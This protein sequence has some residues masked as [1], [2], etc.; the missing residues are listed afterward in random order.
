MW[1]DLPSDWQ[2]S[3]FDEQRNRYVTR[4]YPHSR[5]FVSGIGYTKDSKAVARRA[6]MDDL[7]LSMTSREVIEVKQCYYQGVYDL[8]WNSYE[9]RWD[10]R[11]SHYRAACRRSEDY[12]NAIRSNV[13][14]RFDMQGQ[15][16]W[17]WETEIVRASFD[18]RGASV[19]VDE[20]AFQYTRSSSGDTVYY[21]AGAK[22]ITPPDANGVSAELVPDGQALRLRVSDKWAGSYAGET[23]EVS[24]KLMYVTSGW[25]TRNEVVDVRAY[26]QGNQIRWAPSAPPGAPGSGGGFEES[27]ATKGCGTYYLESWSFRR[28]NNSQP[29]NKSLISSD[30][31]V[32]KG[33]SQR[34]K[35]CR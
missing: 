18:G 3:Q 12:G 7:S 13:S 29:D 6:G 8:R 30:G 1:A 17:P 5:P 27:L 4:W 31:I 2:Q 34:I 35:L 25:F 9:G 22:L 28:A 26:P 23:L 21:R 11:F 32:S 19:R 14:V 10:G 24:L 15:S 16:M 20:P 33:G